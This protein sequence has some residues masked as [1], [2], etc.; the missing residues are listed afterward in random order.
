MTFLERS[1]FITLRMEE[2]ER[3]KAEMENSRSK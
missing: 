1:A 2:A 3:E